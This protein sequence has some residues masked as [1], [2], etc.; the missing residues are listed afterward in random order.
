MKVRRVRL[1]NGNFKEQ[2][3]LECPTSI[4]EVLSVTGVSMVT[5]TFD[6]GRE[7]LWSKL[8]EMKKVR[9]MPTIPLGK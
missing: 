6:D 5:I 8:P 7:T 1:D 4:A 2:D 3:D 9:P